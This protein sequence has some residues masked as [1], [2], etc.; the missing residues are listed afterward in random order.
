MEQTTGLTGLGSILCSGWSKHHSLSVVFKNWWN[1]HFENPYSLAWSKLKSIVAHHLSSVWKRFC[2][3]CTCHEAWPYFWGLQM[4]VPVK[5]TTSKFS[6]LPYLYFFPLVSSMAI[7]ALCYHCQTLFKWL[8]YEWIQKLQIIKDTQIIG[9]FSRVSV[10]CAAARFLLNEY[11]QWQWDSW[12]SGSV[13][14]WASLLCNSLQLWGKKMTAIAQVSFECSFLSHKWYFETILKGLLVFYFMLGL[15]V[16]ITQ[17]VTANQQLNTLCL[18]NASISYLAQLK[19]NWWKYMSNGIWK[20][21][22]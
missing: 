10:P 12:S 19:I 6:F 17:A 3:L 11:I 2:D 14:K 5:E 1:L 22:L 4:W 15:C 9:P 18:V 21:L 20:Y 16:I 7:C 13:R 8:I